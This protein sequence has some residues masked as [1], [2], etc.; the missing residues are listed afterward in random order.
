MV[1]GGKVVTHPIMTNPWQKVAHALTYMDGPKVY[2]WKRDAETWILSTPVPS[3]PTMTIYDDFE[4][5]FIMLWT[6]TN[7][8]YRAVAELDK[9]RMTDA[10][11]N[12]YI[13]IFAKLVR[14]V[15]YHK[16]DPA[17]LKKFK[18]G[19][20]LELLEPYMHHDDPRS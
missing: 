1:K 4:V 8:L 15:L 11:I 5:A 19:L 18:S 20:P 3:A 14:K 13:T 16:D 7:E 10:N 2:E 17:V 6:N 12:E 9:L